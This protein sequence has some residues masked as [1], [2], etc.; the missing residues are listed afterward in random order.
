M[1]TQVGIVGA[2]PAGLLLSHLLHL[3]GIESIVLETR[4]REY[5]ERRIRAGVLER[6][7]VDLL[8]ATGL[9][10]RMRR[11][12]ILHRGVTIRF[13][14]RS[15]RIDLVSL[16]GKA[17]TV[18]GQHEIVKDLIAARLADGG[19]TLFD[20]QNVSLLYLDSDSPRIKL[21]DAEGTAKEITCDFVAGCDGSRG[22]ARA[23]IPAGAL[24]TFDR[25]YPMAW[26]GIL[27]ESPP[28]SGELM[29]SSHENGLAL[30]SMRSP[31]ISRM[32]LQVPPDV[33]LGEW[34][35]ERIWEEFRRRLEGVD[36]SP[37]P[38]EGPILQRGVTPLRSFVAEPISFGRLFLAGDAAHIV[39]PTGAKGMNLAVADVAVLA[40]ALS[41]F[42]QDGRTDDLRSYSET[43]LRRVWKA[44]RF[45]MYMTNLLHRIPDH[46]PFERRVQ[47]AELDYLVHSEAALR[48]LAENYVGLPLPE[49]ILDA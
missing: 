36:D 33:D 34:P 40:R 2:G 47:Q 12:G 30:F 15:H 16:T 17:V 24:T 23:S 10:N 9:G 48:S 13:G 25:E 22:V 6:G 42:Y 7:T 19:P 8:N 49:G 45:S 11:E 26:L 21:L 32:Y 39:P 5:V 27:A 3:R 28:L 20:V 4:S 14:G 37:M 29:Y 35:D 46:S 44:E 41:R 31:T 18:Y 38:E 43:C 1:R